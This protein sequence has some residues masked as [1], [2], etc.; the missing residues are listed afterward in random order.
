MHPPFLI[1]ETGTPITPMR[2][3]GSFGHWI[4]VAAGLAPTD[5]R[6]WSPPTEP[7][8]PDATAF[9]GIIVS[10]SGA[11]VSEREPW[12]ERTAA[13][14]A[15]AVERGLPVF[16]ICYGHQLLAHALGGEV[17]YNPAGRQMGTQTVRRADVPGD[18]LFSALPACFRAQTTHVQVVRRL[19][20]NAAVLASTALDPH[21]AFRVGDR[22]WGVQFHPEFATSHMR[23]YIRA[24]ATALRGERHDPQ[25]MADAVRAAPCARQVLRRFV[26]FARHC[27]QHARNR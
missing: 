9:A 6:R 13:W 22:A 24:R 19:P 25:A 11:M 14:L 3:H 7:E 12:S 17:D 27:Q 18:P 23:G 16:G 5:A 2:R 4:R 1:V 10:G 15:A 21:H 26:R 20:A 8:T